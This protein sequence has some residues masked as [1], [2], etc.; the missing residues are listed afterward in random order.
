MG[1]KRE[2]SKCVPKT[3]INMNLFFVTLFWTQMAPLNPVGLQFP[4]F[5]TI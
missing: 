4:Q 3:E 5:M 2:T 1:G